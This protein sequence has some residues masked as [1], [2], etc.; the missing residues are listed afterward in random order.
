MHCRKHTLV[1][2]AAPRRRTLRLAV[3]ACLALAATPRL[4][5]AQEGSSPPPDPDVPV[6]P[7]E[8]IEVQDETTT[9]GRRARRLTRDR[10]ARANGSG[11]RSEP[12][13]RIGGGIGFGETSIDAGELG[14]HDHEDAIV[15]RLDVEFWVNPYIGFGLTS[16]VV[17]TGDDLFEGQQIE[18]G[19]GPRPADAQ[20]SAHDLAFFFAWDPFGGDHFRFPLHIGPWFAGT[21]LDYDRARIDYNI[22][23]V[24]IRAAAK[25][26]WKLLDREKVDL[27]AFAGA[28]YA[29]GFTSIHEDLIGRNET[30][31]SE[32]QQF[33]AEGGLRVDLRR[34]SL[35]LHYVYSDTG[36]NLSDIENGRRLPEIDYH[37]H[38][39]FFTVGGRF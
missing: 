33:R 36:V 19:A 3:A 28:S 16:E 25:P 2:T 38:M 37:T 21:N 15:L 30:Y 24:G 11:E 18:S 9:E 26:E 27:V 22:A 6:T 10:R 32:S 4:S 23:T 20:L 29:I 34:V 5:C 13:A 1:S 31:D 39:F 7:I 35:G 8:T 17:G 14:Q 12:R